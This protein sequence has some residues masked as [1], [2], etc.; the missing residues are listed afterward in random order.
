[1]GKRTVKHLAV[2]FAVIMISLMGT[3]VGLAIYYHNAFTYGTWI[4]GVYCTGKSIRE[5]NEELV[6]DFTYEG[7]TIYDRDGNVYVSPAEDIS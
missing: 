4:N 1:M 6:K 2:M 5:V 7:L 3:Y